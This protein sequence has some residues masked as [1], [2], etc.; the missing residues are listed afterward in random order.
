MPVIAPHLIATVRAT[1]VGIVAALL[2]SAVFGAA[3]ALIPAVRTALYPLVI[4]SQTVPLIAL[5]PLFVL[6]FGF[7]LLPKVLVVALVCFFPILV[8]LIEGQDAVDPDQIDLLRSMGAGRLEIFR[9]VLVPASIPYLFAGLRISATYSV[10]G[11]V[12]GEWLG[13]SEGIGVY[14]LRSQKA[15][16]LDR[17]F[18][19]IAIVVALSF[20]VFGIVV[21]AQYVATPWTRVESRNGR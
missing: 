13:G 1:V 10:M 18:A 12:I 11:A 8:N 20:C 19:A 7:G 17:V 21:A 3:M 4:V 6:W 9:R 14:M 16:A 15:F 2:V 5:A